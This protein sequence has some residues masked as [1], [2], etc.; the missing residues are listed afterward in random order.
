MKVMISICVSLIMVAGIATLEAR[1][2]EGL[3]AAWLFDE[4]SDNV[5]R[6]SIGSNDGETQGS[7]KWVDGRFG[8][9]L[10]FPGQGDSY[11]SISHHDVMDSDPYTI[12]A[13]V[14]LE[15]ASWQY[16]AWKNG[17]TWPEPHAKRHTDIWIHQA[18]YAVIMWS[19]EGGADYGRVDGG[20]IIA[21]GNWHH[22]AKSSDGSTMRLYIDGKLDGEAPTGGKLVAN[23]EDPLW[24]GARPGNVA[25]TGVID[26][27]GFF[28][29]ALSEDELKDVMTKG[30]I[31]P[32]SVSPASKLAST[33]AKL[34]VTPF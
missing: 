1:G 15:P 2:V 32:S 28:T 23:G 19:F 30:L 14:K 25:A 9:A 17:L 7:L 3:A 8:K 4:G 33:W 13:W 5:V 12:A 10:E 29:R 26:E 11:V 31:A 18:G 16:I 22:V 20:T 21:D 34:K 27:V 24:I 6:D